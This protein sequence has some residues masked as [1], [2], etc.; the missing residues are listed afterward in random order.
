MCAQGFDLRCR[1]GQHIHQPGDVA[2]QGQAAVLEHI[3]LAPA[4]C[5]AHQLAPARGNLIGT[6]NLE[7]DSRDIPPGPHIPG[8]LL[9]GQPYPFQPGQQPIAHQQIG[10]HHS[11]R[12]AWIGQRCSDRIGQLVR[13]QNSP[14]AG[15][16]PHQFVVALGNLGRVHIGHRLVTAQAHRGGLPAVEAQGGQAIPRGHSFGQRLVHGHIGRTRAGFVFEEQPPDGSGE[17]GHCAVRTGDSTVWA[18]VNRGL[19]AKSSSKS[20]QCNP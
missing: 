19:I 12:H 10:I 18:W 20:G 3:T 4:L 2:S 16:A 7:A 11:A 13:V 8:G 15:G 6:G 9:R 1:Q 5:A 14:S 17:V